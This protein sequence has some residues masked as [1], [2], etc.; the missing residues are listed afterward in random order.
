MLAKQRN[1]SIKRIERECGIANATIRKWETQGPSLDSIK[2]VAE[3]LQVSLDYIVYG[4]EATMTSG[5][6][7]LSDDE[8]ELIA[9]Y[10]QLNQGDK[11]ETRDHI[12]TK[13]RLT[14]TNAP[15]AVS[16]TSHNGNG[17]MEKTDEGTAT[18]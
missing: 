6:L 17:T 10:R 18:A 8:I 1:T 9:Q 5:G 3:N 4:E 2:K 16:P 15:K 7:A 13:L 12:A 11:K 14:F